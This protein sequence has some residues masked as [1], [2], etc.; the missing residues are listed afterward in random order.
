LKK[1]NQK[2]KAKD[3]LQSFSRSKKPRNTTEK[4]VVRTLSPKA[5]AP[6]LTYDRRA[7]VFTKNLVI[8]LIIRFLGV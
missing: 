8:I 2:F 6:L 7:N 3:Q 5:A 4:I 1:K